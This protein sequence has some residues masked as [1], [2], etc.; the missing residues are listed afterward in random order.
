MNV[1]AVSVFSL[2]DYLSKPLSYLLTR[3]PHFRTAEALCALD[4]VLLFCL[5]LANISAA[6]QLSFSLCG[7][8]P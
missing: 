6:R 3:L 8:H 7:L 2:G 1:P 5:Q 4:V